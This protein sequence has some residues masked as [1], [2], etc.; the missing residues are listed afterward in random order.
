MITGGCLL[1]A[2]PLIC[3][4]LQLAGAPLMHNHL[5]DSELLEDFLTHQAMRANFHSRESV[6]LSSWKNDASDFRCNEQETEVNSHIGTTHNNTIYAFTHHKAGT[7][8]MESIMKD[9]ASILGRPFRDIS[10]YDID[11]K[12]LIP[13]CYDDGS[14]VVARNAD[15]ALTHRIRATC[16]DFRAIHMVREAMSLT[17]SG[18]LY[19]RWNKHDFIHGSGPHVLGQAKTLE[20]QLNIEARAQSSTIL[21]V[22]A[23][24]YNYTK[25][26][27]HFLQ[28][29]FEQIHDNY[30]HAVRQ[31]FQHALG[32]NHS[33]LDRLVESAQRHDVSRW[34]ADKIASTPHV[35]SV[36][37]R[38][39][40]MKTFL[41]MLDRQVPAIAN[42]E[43]FDDVLEYGSPNTN[44][45]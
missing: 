36:E 17:A 43:S 12:S 39:L 32:T 10:Y 7:V 24:F 25:G 23:R 33:Q 22:L 20:E 15:L 45:T 31:L 1:L 19:H 44:K 9:A 8:L 37:D 13:Q 30:D 5:D 6:G 14:I 21:P 3:H 38:S 29:R 27:R 34:S 26:D 18:Y 4:G 11:G 42:L 28:L 35:A 2:L 41:S 40:V 16:P